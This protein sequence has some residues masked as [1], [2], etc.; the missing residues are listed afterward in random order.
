MKKLEIQGLKKKYNGKW[1]IKGIDLSINEKECVALIGP[2]GAGKSTM[3]NMI[4]QILTQDEGQ[5]TLDGKDAKSVR[6][7]IGFL[8]QYP[9]FYGWMSATECLH[10]MGKLSNMEKKDLEARIQEVLLLVGLEASA[11]KKISTYSGGMRQRLGIAQA[12][13]HRPELLVLD[14]PVSALDP[15]GR[16]EMMLLLDKLKKEI[17]I[18][19]S[20]HILKD[21]EEICDR[22]AIIKNG[23]LVADNTVSQ[24]I[25]EESSPVFDVELN[26]DSDTWQK[27]LLQN[28]YV[29]KIE[30][31]G[32]VYQVFTTNQKAGAEAIL[33]SLL[34]IDGEFIRVENR[35]QS[36]EEI[37]MEK[38]GK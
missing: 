4:V 22:I 19:F 25:K 20:T 34:N 32:T 16:R 8:P 36:L 18:L 31:V 12:I 29:E 10:F 37:F 5:I 3:I 24:L 2:N 23:E 38:V 9:E 1:V 13:L 33:S 30:K 6:E 27:E 35:H 7:K 28:N 11:N 17:T 26:G 15:I 14:E 21:A